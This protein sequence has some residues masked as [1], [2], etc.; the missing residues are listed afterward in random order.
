MPKQF[1]AAIAASL[2]AGSLPAQFLEDLK[3][4]KPKQKF[5]ELTFS[6]GNLAASR[7]T[8]ELTATGDI[9]AESG[10]YRFFTDKLTR[11]A[12]G[13]YDFGEKAMFTTCSNDLDH[14][15]WKLEGHFIYETDKSITGSDIWLYFMDMP[16]LWVP[17]MYYPLNT[18][19]GF[20]FLPGY[21]NRWG[22]FFLSGYV[23]DIYNEFGNGPL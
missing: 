17:W 8:G 23:Y 9:V 5:G 10:D 2:L 21:M 7:K 22:C 15:H 11:S 13:V 3:D 20:R 6:G 18:N 14:L 12:S 16:V 19:Y 1:L 4:P